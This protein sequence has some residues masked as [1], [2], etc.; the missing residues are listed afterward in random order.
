METI[1]VADAKQRFT[2]LVARAAAGEHIIIHRP[3][4][5]AAVLISANEL[6]RLERLSLAARQLALA[7]GQKVELL[8]QIESG[9]VHPVMAAFGLWKGETGFDQLTD[10][11]YANRQNPS[12]RTEV[13][14]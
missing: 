13:K 2:E 4:Q 14:W 9:Q 6:D 10:Q 5:P 11:I 1:D 12:T 8:E 3:D 7:L